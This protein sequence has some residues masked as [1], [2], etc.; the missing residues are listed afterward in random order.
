[1]ILLAFE[2]LA[3][4]VAVLAAANFLYVAAFVPFALRVRRAPPPSTEPRLAVLVP[5]H[6][7]AAVIDG[8]VA[9]LQRVDYPQERLHVLFVADH[10]SDD[11]AARIRAGGYSCLERQ[12]GDRG[13]S[14]ALRDGTAFLR[15]RGWDELDGVAFFDADNLVDPGFF[16]AA[17]GYLAAGHAVV[18]GRVGMHNWDETLF[19]RVT[20]V[21]GVVENRF[22]E[23]AHSQAGS[24]CHLRGHGMLFRKDVLERLGWQSSALVEDQEMLVRLVLAGER[25][26]WAE[27]AR[28]NSILPASTQAAAAQRRRWAGGHAAIAGR[29]VRQLLPR[30]LRH[31]D[32][33]ALDLALDFMAPSYAVQL[34]LVFAATVLGALLTALG[35]AGWPLAVGLLLLVGYFAVFA[36]G[37]A[38]GGVRLRTFASCAA[39]PFYILWRTWIRLTSAT[40]TRRWR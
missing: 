6:D 22:K 15:E 38:L 1:M 37:A 34:S 27:D 35:G 31:G 3:G 30:F 39:A 7:E 26:V 19:T 5:A 20:H 25:V 14:P 11:T 8:L 9:S 13:K 40:G 18:Q 10:C 29:S 12:S 16:K 17:A 32:L 4:G 33:T 24:T 2:I 23:L 21:S 28:V 36:L